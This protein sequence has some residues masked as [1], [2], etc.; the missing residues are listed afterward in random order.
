[1]QGLIEYRADA[2]ICNTCPVKV[3]CTG[4]DHG[5]GIHHSW[6][7]A[8]LDRV[9]A[10]HGTEAYQKAMRKRQVWIEPLFGEAKQWHGLRRFRLRGLEKVNIEALLIASGQNVKRLLQAMGG[11]IHPVPGMGLFAIGTG[12]KSLAEL[13]LPEGASH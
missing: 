2:R 7:Q 5:R 6:Y 10:Y 4:S 12:M 13:R 1:M 11:R 9:R 8:Y 3:A